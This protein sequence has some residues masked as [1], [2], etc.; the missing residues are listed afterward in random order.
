MRKRKSLAFKREKPKVVK[1]LFFP[2]LAF[3]AAITACAPTVTALPRREIQREATISETIRRAEKSCKIDPGSWLRKGERL[4]STLCRDGRVFALTG[5]SLLI[6]READ[7]NFLFSDITLESTHSRTDMR[8]ILKA[9]LV[10]WTAS[11]DT[12]YFLTRDGMLTPIPVGEMGDELNSYQIPQAYHAGNIEFHNDFLLI[13]GQG[14]MMAVSFDPVLDSREIPFALEAKNSDF[15]F[16]EGRLFFGE[17]G[18][19]VEIIFEGS[20]LSDI[21]VR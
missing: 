16:Q 12:A 5:E 8:D 20:G 11:H 13:A 10:D 9:G 21:R 7:R 6:G 1:K 14:K 18:K 19:R 3:A 17:K 2:M 15:F 4:R